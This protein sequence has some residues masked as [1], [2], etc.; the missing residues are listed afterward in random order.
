MWEGAKAAI[1]ATW[2]AAQ[3]ALI[4]TAGRRPDGAFGF[5]MFSESSTIEV[6]LFRETPQ[7]VKVEVE[8]GEWVAKDAAGVP[9]RIAW[10]AHV[11]EPGLGVFGARMHA[12]Y[13][14]AAQVQRW[15]AALE[16]VAR[17]IPEDAETRALAL[18][19][20]V[21]KNGRARTVTAVEARR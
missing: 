5:R 8:G 1:A 21:R 3:I 9:H 11:K 17:H 19:L 13:G 16:Y 4:A 15:S 14:A 12:S 20:A 10:G 18:E 2:I 6:R 7:G